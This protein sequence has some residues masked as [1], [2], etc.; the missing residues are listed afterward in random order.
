MFAMCAYQI[1]RNV[2]LKDALCSSLPVANRHVHQQQAR[3]R[4]AM[5]RMPIHANASIYIVVK[6][7]VG[8]GNKSLV[9]NLAALSSWL[10]LLRF[11]RVARTPTRVPL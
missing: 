2:L 10:L 11:R 8:S 9:A 7:I 1:Q 3:L 5:A 6:N 4:V